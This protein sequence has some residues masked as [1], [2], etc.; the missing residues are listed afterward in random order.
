MLGA[1]KKRVFM[2]D[3]NDRHYERKHQDMQ[4]CLDNRYD[5]IS[6]ME[7]MLADVEGKLS[8]FCGEQITGK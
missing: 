7:K 4:E 8:V 1:K 6:E 2:L 5:R 3:V